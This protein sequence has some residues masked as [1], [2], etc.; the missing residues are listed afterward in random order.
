MQ[1][2]KY[3]RTALHL[4]ATQDRLDATQALVDA[5]ADL[6]SQD[7]KESTPIDYAEDRGYSAVV[8]IL[9]A[10]KTT[11]LI[12]AA[13]HQK[14]TLV[15]S[16]LSDGADC[17]LA[18]KYGK[19]ALLYAIKGNNYDIV[20][21]MIKDKNILNSTHN[22]SALHDA[23]YYGARD[24]MNCLLDANVN[25]R[26]K[27]NH[28][29]TVMMAAARSKTPKL[30]II[31]TMYKRHVSVNDVNDDGETSLMFASKTGHL[32]TVDLLLEYN[33]DINIKN[34]HH[35]TALHFAAHRGCPEHMKVLINAK[36]NV[37]MRE[38]SDGW[39]PLHWSVQHG[40]LDNVRLLVEA[41]ANLT[42][43]TYCARMTPLKFAE[44]AKK[45]LIAKYLRELLDS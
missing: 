24:I 37:N 39:T 27:D 34:K 33:A 20:R 19:T 3:G 5:H 40:Y 45:Y 13:K 9:S 1:K 11:P 18:D 43:K 12:A 32:R 22:R 16:L 42:S 7:R 38:K 10:H 17:N 14:W 35:W 36:A 15:E 23:A 29:Q 25:P 21:M 31:T 6:S 4:A 28:G 8:H 30:D 26:I 44:F 41:K 2:N